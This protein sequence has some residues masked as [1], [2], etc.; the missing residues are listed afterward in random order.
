MPS[1]SIK[2]VPAEIGAE[3]LVIEPRAQ[4]RMARDEELS[5]YD[6]A[7]LGLAVQLRCPLVTFDQKLGAAARRLLQDD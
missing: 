5:A 6:A 4:W 2:H 7:Y 3:P 1:L